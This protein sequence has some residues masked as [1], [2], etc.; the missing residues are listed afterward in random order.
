[1]IAAER[2][3]APVALPPAPRGRR[4]A[5]DRPRV[6]IVVA[7]LAFVFLFLPIL[8]VIAFSFNSERSLQTFGHFDLRWYR[9]F[10]QD[11]ASQSSLRASLEI[12]LISSIVATTLGTALALGIARAGRRLARPFQSVVVLTLVT[13]EIASA[14]ALLLLLTALG[15]QLSNFTVILGHITFSI[16]FV[17]VVVSGRLG[18]LNAH[19]EEAA[20]DLGASTFTT[21]RLVVLPQ[22]APAVLGA[23]LLSF[24]LSF[25]DFVTSLFV[26]GTEVSPLPVRIY[27]M[28][29][30][31][32]TPQVNA[33]GTLMTLVTVVLGVLA[34]LVLMRRRRG[35]S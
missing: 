33:I 15:T 30:T 19:L 2:E 31:G 24:V 20:M 16:G 21:M 4:G 26:S 13:P 7:V 35:E 34:Y 23:L 8:A 14:V 29:R 1:V 10:F 18:H 22:I 17:V 12:A 27:G 11:D 25:G 32:V 5:V 6:L 3:R 9:A 28:L